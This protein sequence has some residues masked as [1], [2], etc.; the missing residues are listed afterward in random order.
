M[1]LLDNDSEGRDALDR[2][3]RLGLPSNMNV[4]VLPK[5]DAFRSFPT[6]GP[7]GD[8]TEDVNGRAASIELFLDLHHP[9]SPQPR[10]RWTN[11]V[12]R[13]GE[14]QGQLEAKE[15]FTRNFFEAARRR[16][17][18]YDFSKLGAVWDGIIDA[19]SE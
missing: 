15:E 14:Y 7:A 17:M 12:A 5:L 1:I 8:S 9:A 19:C 4:L 3:S 10:I 2:I 16:D 13:V 18:S 6:V 11:Y